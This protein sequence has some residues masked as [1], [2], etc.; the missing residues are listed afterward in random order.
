MEGYYAKDRKTYMADASTMVDPYDRVII[1]VPVYAGKVPSLAR[2]FLETIQGKGKA[3]T[4]VV[5]YGNRDYGVAIKSLKDLLTEN[6]FNVDSAGAFIA[7]HSYSDFMPIAIGRPDSEDLAKAKLFGAG[8]APTLHPLKET[9]IPIE[10]DMIANSNS[11]GGILPYYNATNCKE[12][13][14]CAAYCPVGIIEE[15]T[16]KFISEEA[17][18]SC[19][20]CMSCV[21][22]CPHEGRQLKPGFKDRL[23]H[24]LVLGKAVKTRREPIYVYG[25]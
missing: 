19:I 10:A 9:D 16:G 23:M 21:K 1:G 17:V 13:G 24:K 18:S 14:T 5:V 22:A 12:C 4:V 3:A 11:E 20:K 2:P 7:Q 8:I 6:G 25:S 15:G